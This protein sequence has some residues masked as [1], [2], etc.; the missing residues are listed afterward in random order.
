MTMTITVDETER[1]W[2]L[3]YSFNGG[4]AC[5]A[6]EDESEAFKTRT[7]ALIAA[8]DA[9]ERAREWDRRGLAD[10]PHMDNF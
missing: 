6:P 10:A 1:G 7:E 8:A 9:R 2:E 3:L 4:P 5:F